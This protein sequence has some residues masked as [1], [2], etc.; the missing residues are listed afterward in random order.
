MTARHLTVRD[1]PKP[2]ATALDRESRRRG[3][4]LNQTV[5]DLLARALGLESKAFDN[6]LGDLAGTWDEGELQQFERDTAM[7]SQVDEELWR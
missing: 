5:K 1:L 6:G 7:F 3:V 2:L 4:S